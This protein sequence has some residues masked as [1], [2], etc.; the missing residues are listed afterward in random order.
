MHFLYSCFHLHYIRS[1]I[2]RYYVMNEFQIYIY[3]CIS[4]NNLSKTRTN[5]VLLQSLTIWMPGM[6]NFWSIAIHQTTPVS[7][8]TRIHWHK[9]CKSVFPNLRYDVW[10]TC[11]AGPHGGYMPSTWHIDRF[12]IGDYMLLL[13]QKL[14]YWMPQAFLMGWWCDKENKEDTT[15]YNELFRN[16]GASSESI[17]EEDA[18][19]SLYCHHMSPR[20]VIM[21]HNVYPSEQQLNSKDD[22]TS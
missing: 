8:N 15:S 12:T 4:R 20:G 2:S 3:T 11:T 19:H 10:L 21:V 9:G 18:G 1:A 17:S 14:N 16:N 22:A 6:V 13:C 5:V 7:G